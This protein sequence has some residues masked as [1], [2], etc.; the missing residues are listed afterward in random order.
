MQRRTLLK[1]SSLCDFPKSLWWVK[2][3]V[4]RRKIEF[5]T[6][7]TI[8]STETKGQRYS[9]QMEQIESIWQWFNDSCSQDHHEKQFDQSNVFDQMANVVDRN[10]KNHRI[11]LKTYMITYEREKLKFSVQLTFWHEDKETIK[12]IKVIHEAKAQNRDSYACNSYRCHLSWNRIS[13]ITRTR[14]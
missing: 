6:T 9:R 11:M 1:E 10:C 13:Y 14:Q 3:K 4:K 7:V 5:L 12:L 2:C 8:N